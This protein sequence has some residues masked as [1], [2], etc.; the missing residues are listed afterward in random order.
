LIFRIP[1]ETLTQSDV[2][3][4]R[5]CFLWIVAADSAGHLTSVAHV[6]HFLWH[7]LGR[8]TAQQLTCPPLFPFVKKRKMSNNVTLGIAAPAPADTGLNLDDEV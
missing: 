6:S 4:I 2:Y 5:I 8:P 3:I 7:S 1:S